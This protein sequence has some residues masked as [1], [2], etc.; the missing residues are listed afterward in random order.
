MPQTSPIIVPDLSGLSHGVPVSVL[1]DEWFDCEADLTRACDLQDELQ[2]SRQRGRVFERLERDI[3]AQQDALI[4][5]QARLQRSI[6]A[7]PCVSPTD[8]AGKAKLIATGDM[9]PDVVC[10]LA[11]DI[12]GWLTR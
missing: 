2:R 7:T 5:R 3:D 9:D 6:S 4:A 11:E 8:A 10:R 12:A 1:V